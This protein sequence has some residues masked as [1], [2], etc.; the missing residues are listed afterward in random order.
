MGAGD[1]EVRT[2]SALKQ[3]SLGATIKVFIHFRR[4]DN[5]PQGKQIGRSLIENLITALEQKGGKLFHP[6]KLEGRKMFA[7]I[8]PTKRKPKNTNDA[9]D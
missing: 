8:A 3:L 5:N 6:I 4:A 7:I 1:L 2:K 9:K